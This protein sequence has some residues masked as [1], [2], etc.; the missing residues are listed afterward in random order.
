M[1]KC[2]CRSRIVPGDSSM[3]GGKAKLPRIAAAACWSIAQSE[4]CARRKTATGSNSIEER[5]DLLDLCQHEQRDANRRTKQRRQNHHEKRLRNH[6]ANS[7]AILRS[8]PAE[9]RLI[10]SSHASLNA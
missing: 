7:H 5:L 3:S 1:E 2:T 9:N 4:C 6:D 10:R 8:A